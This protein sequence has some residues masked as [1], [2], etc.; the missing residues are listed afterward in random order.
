MSC[1]PGSGDCALF[2]SQPLLYLIL[3]GRSCSGDG[4]T[5]TSPAPGWFPWVR[6]PCC[7]HG[8][9]CLSDFLVSCS[10]RAASGRSNSPGRRCF[11]ELAGT[12][13]IACQDLGGV[14]SSHIREG[15]VQLGLFFCIRALLSWVW[16]R[17]CLIG[18]GR[19]NS[20]T[21]W[22]LGK[23]LVLEVWHGKGC[24]RTRFV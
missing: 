24:L 7:Q 6:G 10:S 11:G 2:S 9:E 15:F 21:L 18:I 13:S 12:V 16:L 8:P 5:G 20:C 3:S 22:P 1:G 23:L 4:G 14:R 19:W 17:L